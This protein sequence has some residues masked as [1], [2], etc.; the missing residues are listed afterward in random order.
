ME[1]TGHASAWEIGHSPPSPAAATSGTPGPATLR[2]W[3]LDA[4]LAHRAGNG[5]ERSAPSPRDPS[6]RER[7]R[8]PA[9]GAHPRVETGLRHIHA[10]SGEPRARRSTLRKRPN[11]SQRLRT[12][13]TASGLSG[14]AA[15]VSN[16]PSRERSNRNHLW[17]GSAVTG[18]RTGSSW[19]SAPRAMGIHSVN[20]PVRWR[21]A[22]VTA[23]RRSVLT[24]PPGLRG[25]RVGVRRWSGRGRRSLPS[26][27]SHCAV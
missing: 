9:V 10:E 14:A 20:D 23:S 12:S 16:A 25:I 15:S 13:Q 1:S 27:H 8:I 24:R 5:S 26:P 6:G 11:V 18:L 4:G 21:R 7:G 19:P 2:Q 3:Y 22:R 17:P